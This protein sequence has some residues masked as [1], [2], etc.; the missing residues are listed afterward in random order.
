MHHHEATG[1]EPAE[2]LRFAAHLSRLAQVTAAEETSVI[3][4]VLSD[5]DQV[6]ARSAVLRH[7][8]LRADRLH[9][10]PTYQPWQESMAHTIARHPFLAR[11]L[12]EWTLFR[13]IVLKQSWSPDALLASSDWLQRK[14]AAASNAHAVEVLAERGRTKRVRDIARTTGKHL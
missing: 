1:D 11:R 10:D 6:M 5:P 12:R 13:A 9:L 7:L 8:D 4:A 14:V 3:S 2:H